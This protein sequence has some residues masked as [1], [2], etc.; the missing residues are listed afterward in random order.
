MIKYV[1]KIGGAF[2]LRMAVTSIIG[3]IVMWGKT[4][5]YAPH[6]LGIGALTAVIFLGV[7][8]VVDM[9]RIQKRLEEMTKEE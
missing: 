2:L 1:I 6:A 8:I 3:F 5:N 4:D 7:D 9:I